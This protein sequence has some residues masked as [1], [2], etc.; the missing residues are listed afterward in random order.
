MATDA[1]YETYYVPAD[2]K[3]PIFASLGIFLTVFGLGNWF[4]DL[5]AGN[6][7]SLGVWILFLGGLVM[8]G[9]LFVWFSK[10][11]EENHAK[12]YSQQMNRSFV[13]GMSWFIF[14]E[15]MFFAAF[16]GAL[17]YIRVLAVPWIG[18]EGARGPTD[19]LWPD[20]VPEWPLINT[21]DPSLFPG[22]KRAYGSMGAAAD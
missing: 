19:M 15:V 1:T 9:T 2:S 8:G 3:L 14:S 10:V 11:I 4:N 16:F 13:W 17:F 6:E 20:Y 21:P 18:G 22:A 12:M 5:T 7:S